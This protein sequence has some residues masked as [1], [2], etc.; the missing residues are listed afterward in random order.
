MTS[1]TMTAAR[2]PR[3]GRA[4]DLTV[5]VAPYPR[6]SVG[7]VIVEVHAAAFTPGE[8]DWEP[9]Y[10]DRAGRDRSPAIPA[11]DVSGVVV[12]LGFGTNPSDLRIG[13]RVLGMID[14]YRDG[15]AAEFVAVEGRDL[16]LVPDGIDHVQA[17]SLPMSGLTAWQ[18]LVVH[19]GLAA[20]QRVLIHGAGGAVGTLAVQLARNA[21]AEVIGTGRARDRQAVL[22]AGAS[23][24]LDLAE[25]ALES[26]SGSMDLVFDMIGGEVLARSIELIAP[27]GTLVSIAAPPPAQPA[28][29][30]A[31]YFIVEPNRDQLTELANLL[32]TGAIRLP[33]ATVHP[34]TEAPK[35][36]AD[37]ENGV[38]GK[39]VLQHKP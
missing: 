9:T 36:F 20:G 4:A 22:D 32:A 24:F 18:G 19:G 6:A 38:P 5:E 15:A 34:L 33:E 39:F 23:S 26:L 10:V 11:R 28:D 27:G 16:A 12:E 3:P 7:D 31:V 29:G 8:L 17:A 30:R 35:A 2:M 21:G 37:K 14:R 13:D 1:R 25:G